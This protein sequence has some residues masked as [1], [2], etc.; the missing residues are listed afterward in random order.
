M[1]TLQRFFFYF[2][3]AGMMA[4]IYADHDAIPEPVSADNLST[5]ACWLDGKHMGNLSIWWGHTTAG[6]CMGMQ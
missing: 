3:F 5:W 1:T 4:T 2:L 6:R